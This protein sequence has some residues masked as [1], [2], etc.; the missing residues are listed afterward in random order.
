MHTCVGLCLYKQNFS[1]K[2]PNM[3]RRNCT[4]TSQ[5]LIKI[6]PAYMYILY[7]DH[8]SCLPKA[9]FSRISLLIDVSESSPT[10]FHTPCN[11]NM[12]AFQFPQDPTPSFCFGDG[13]RQTANGSSEGHRVIKV[14]LGASLWTLCARNHITINTHSCTCSHTLKHA[15]HNSHPYLR[16]TK[17]ATCRATLLVPITAIEKRLWT[18]KNT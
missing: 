2:F 5:V 15:H 12:A 18:K 14:R 16:W 6:G 10:I 1:L 9:V 11:V 3:F 17:L 13:W 4:C 8:F 7:K